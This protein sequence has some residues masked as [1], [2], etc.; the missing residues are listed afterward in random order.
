LE[1]AGHDL[2]QIG[3]FLFDFLVVFVQLFQ[4]SF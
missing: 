3:D 2:P 1:R 4:L